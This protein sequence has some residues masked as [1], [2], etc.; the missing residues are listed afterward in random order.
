MITSDSGAEDH[1][2]FH[3]QSL[4]FALVR[5][6]ES[7]AFPIGCALAIESSCHSLAIEH[8]N[9]ACKKVLNHRSNYREVVCVSDGPCIG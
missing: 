3:L 8:S 1:T 5:Q 7:C 9:S 6:N 2:D 4:R